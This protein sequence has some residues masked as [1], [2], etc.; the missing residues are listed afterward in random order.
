MKV[1]SGVRARYWVDHPDET[2]VS[3]VTEPFG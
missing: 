1:K 2:I 3:E